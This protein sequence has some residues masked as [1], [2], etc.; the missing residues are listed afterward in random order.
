MFLK[1]GQTASERGPIMNTRYY[2]CLSRSLIGCCL[3]F[4][5]AACGS[6][7]PTGVGQTPLP[8]ALAQRQ[9]KPLGGLSPRLTCPQNRT[10]ARLLGPAEAPGISPSPRA[11]IKRSDNTLNRS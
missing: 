5:L 8:T 1:P 4:L 11:G 2:R 9:D 10:S 3:I 7:S 6:G